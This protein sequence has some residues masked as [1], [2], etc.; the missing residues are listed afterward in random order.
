MIEIG[1]VQWLKGFYEYINLNSDHSALVKYVRPG[2]SWDEVFWE[3]VENIYSYFDTDLQNEAISAIENYQSEILKIGSCKFVEKTQT[4]NSTK[5]LN[6][7]GHLQLPSIPEKQI[8]EIRSFLND[9]ELM[10]GENIREGDRVSFK[11]AREIM[12]TA[13]LYQ[14]HG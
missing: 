4:I 2:N 5:K 1:P 11:R 7:F 12:N 13:F 9:R 14:D 8:Q 10:I 3:L 6:E